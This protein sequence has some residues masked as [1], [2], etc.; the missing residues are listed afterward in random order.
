MK[1]YR[2]HEKDVAWATGK[3]RGVFVAIWK[4]LEKG[5]L[6]DA[7]EAT[8]YENK[9]YFE[10]VLPVPPFYDEGNP[11][12]AITWYKNNSSGNAISEKMNFY[13]EMA[14]KYDL[15][16]FKTST[17]SVPGEVI[18]EDEFQIA[19]ISSI[20][21]GEGFVVEPFTS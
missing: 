11:E 20:H 5:L 6:S 12:K 19:V 2:I 8:Y 1:Y 18:Y 21:E 3:P 13:F 7:E 17:D 10:E 16:L 9:K 14:K 4:L 15:E